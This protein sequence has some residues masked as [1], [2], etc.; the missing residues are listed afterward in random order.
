PWPRDRDRARLRGADRAIPRLLRA[1]DRFGH[2]DLA[3][4]ERRLGQELPRPGA[5]PLLRDRH[6]A[7]LRR[8]DHAADARRT[9]DHRPTAAARAIRA[10]AGDAACT[11]AAR[12]TPQLMWYSGCDAFK[13]SGPDDVVP[14]TADQRWYAA[15]TPRRPVEATMLAA[16]A[17][18]NAIA[19]PVPGAW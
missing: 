13:I 11:V 17:G 6:D 3:A 10:D 7:V 16:R 18:A 14:V 15:D 4:R 1:S 12:A 5:A 9:R 2:R 19:L 8:H